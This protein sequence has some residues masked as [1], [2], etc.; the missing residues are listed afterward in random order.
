MVILS[1]LTCRFLR[2]YLSQFTFFNT[3]F[4]RS[5]VYDNSRIYTLATLG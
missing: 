5:G 2:R 1:T 4:T 3:D